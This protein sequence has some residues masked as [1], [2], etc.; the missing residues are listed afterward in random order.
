[1]P[2]AAAVEYGLGRAAA[3][4]D[5]TVFSNFWF[6]QPGKAELF[7]NTVS[8]LNAWNERDLLRV[9]AG[10]GGVFILVLVSVLSFGAVSLPFRSKGP[11]KGTR[12]TLE[13]TWLWWGVSLGAV[14][15]LPIAARRNRAAC[16][17]PRPQVP[18]VRVAFELSHSNMRQPYWD[19]PGGAN[20]YHTFYNWTQRLGLIP[21]LHLDLEKALESRPEAVC[22]IRPDGHFSEANIRR[23]RRYLSAGGNLLV[24]E[25]PSQKASTVNQLIRPFGL[26]MDYGRTAA[27][28]VLF[29]ATGPLATISASSCHIIDEGEARD[30]I[31]SGQGGGTSE[32]TAL[33]TLGPDRYVV[34]V[35]VQYG[36][37]ALIVC[38]LGGTFSDSAMG[39]T[40]TTP[41]AA[42]RA[43]YELEYEL[44][45][46][47]LG[48]GTINEAIERNLSYAE[49]TTE[50]PAR[51]GQVPPPS[52]DFP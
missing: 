26:R 39:T 50:G 20:S 15:L 38:S 28:A 27:N 19:L 47:L 49:T 52:P 41:N 11:R 6:F 14:L 13:L 17:E 30:A 10:V 18:Q 16:A 3:F 45:R 8:W 40:R 21:R 36:K 1:L 29:G 5:S 42:T 37:G 46:M 22:L 25:D 9:G 12:G 33:W 23:L 44:W 43:I 32:K 2:Q 31:L 24:L 34:A 51:A 4:T 48:D 7:L 35:K